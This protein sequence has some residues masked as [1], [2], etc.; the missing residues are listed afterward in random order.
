M[1]ILTYLYTL[2]MD[3]YTSLIG[4]AAITGHKWFN[5]FNWAKLENC[6]LHAPFVPKV[7]KDGPG[8]SSEFDS[9]D[10]G[11]SKPVSITI[12]HTMFHV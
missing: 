1:H 12:L 9:F 3:T 8:S 2:H 10:N 4:I 7:K 11:D 6:E 5:S